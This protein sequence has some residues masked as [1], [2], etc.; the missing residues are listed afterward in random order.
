MFY[1][2]FIIFN[3][4]TE[5]KAKETGLWEKN[6]HNSFKGGPTKDNDTYDELK[7]VVTRQSYFGHIF[8]T[9]IFQGIVF[10]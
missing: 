5:I 2:W 4:T 8:V 6:S 3:T 7:E 9:V 1:K 10:L